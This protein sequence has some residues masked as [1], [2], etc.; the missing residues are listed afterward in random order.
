MM[1]NY[2]TE[3]NAI[4]RGLILVSTVLFALG[5]FLPY[6]DLGF[7][8]LEWQALL[9][10]DGDG[11]IL[12]YP[13]WVDFVLFAVTVAVMVMLY[14]YVPIARRLYLIMLIAYAGAGL[15]WGLRITT[16]IEQLIAGLVAMSDGALLTMLYLTSIARRFEPSGLDAR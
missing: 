15:L 4:F 1:S 14:F 6:F 16:P 9:M 10:R 12:T 13:G 8:D 7:Y 2:S 11:A 5:W 3:M